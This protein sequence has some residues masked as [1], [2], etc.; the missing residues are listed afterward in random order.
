MGVY[1][2]LIMCVNDN[3]EFDSTFIELVI[4]LFD[5]FGSL[6][7]PFNDNDIWDPYVV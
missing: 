6:C 4:L 7:G 5:I 2:T 1:E 3:K